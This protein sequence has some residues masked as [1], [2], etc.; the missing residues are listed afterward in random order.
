MVSA[1]AFVWVV[2]AAALLSL[3]PR[4]C[5]ASASVSEVQGAGDTAGAAMQ[6]PLNISMLSLEGL[7][8]QLQVRNSVY[9]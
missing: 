2:S 9:S 7:D 5:R 1:G 3:L 8:A 4:E 6:P